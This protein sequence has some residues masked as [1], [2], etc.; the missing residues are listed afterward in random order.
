MRD[1]TALDTA[2]LRRIGWAWI[3]HHP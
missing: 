2:Q 3:L 1:L